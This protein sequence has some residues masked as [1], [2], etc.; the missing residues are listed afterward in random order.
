MLDAGFIF[1]KHHHH[2]GC[3]FEA[4]VTNLEFSYESFFALKFI[5]L[6]KLTVIAGPFDEFHL[7][8]AL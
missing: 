1:N 2:P 6:H 4:K 8:L 3:D 5:L 7:C